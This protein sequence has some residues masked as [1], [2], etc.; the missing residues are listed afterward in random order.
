V[1]IVVEETKVLTGE[2]QAPPSKSYTHRAIIASALSKGSSKIS[3]PLHSSDITATINA[4]KALGASI[5]KNTKTLKIIGFPE[6]NVYPSYIDCRDSAS[7]LRF[8]TPLVALTKGKTVLDGSV[9]LRRRPVDPLIKALTNLGVHCSSNQGFPPVSV[10]G[11]GLKGGTTSLVGNVSSQF[12]TGLL[13]AC[14]FAKEE[15]KIT[16]TTPLES[17][18]YVN[19]TLDV[20]R[21]HDIAV[22]VSDN[23]RSFKIPANQSYSPRDHVVP[24]DFSS[25]AFLLAAAALTNSVVTVKNLFQNQP[26]SEI[27]KLL[28]KMGVKLRVSNNAVSLLGGKL[29]AID[30]DARDIP[31]LVPV[32]VVLACASEGT[33]NIWGAKR[34]QIKESDRLGALTSE[35]HKMGADVTKTVDGMVIHGPSEL[36][37]GVIDP[38][39]D[40]RIAMACTL[41]GLIA[42]GKTEILEA[43]CVNKSYPNFFEDL[44]ILGAKINVK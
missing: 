8:L 31:D 17:K 16:L 18:P 27:V 26:D 21:Y 23:F 1:L 13:F 38:H 3:F 15:T 30:I 19:L 28:S 20:L 24:G 4:C 11:S 34:L 32:C 5:I 40:H 14:P 39:N 29:K 12:V 2:I 35:L 6:L 36:T 25:A 44:R 37:G 22:E 41:A 9:G 42:K 7:T 33:T 43:Q 10:F